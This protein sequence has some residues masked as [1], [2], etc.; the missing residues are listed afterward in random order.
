MVQT[1]SSLRGYEPI[2]IVGIGC[3]FPGGIVSPATFWDFLLRGQDGT[4]EVPETRW[5]LDRHYDPARGKPG[6]IY[7]KRGGFLENVEGF[8]SQFFGISPREAAY[9]DPQQRLLLEVTWEA[10]EDACIPIT[11]LAR[12]KVGVY[13]GLFTHDYENIH[14]RTTER[15][16][17]SVHSATGMSTTIAANRLSYVFDF[18]GPSMVIDTACSSSLVATHLACRALQAGEADLAVAGGVNLQ[19]A[20]DMAMAL[21][22]ASMLA[23]DGHS[24]SFDARANG[25]ARAEGAGVVVLKPLRKAQEDGDAVYAVIA[26]SAVNQ[27]GHSPGITVPH[28]L[29]QEIVMKEALA[30]AALSGA[31]LTYVEAHGTG[32]PVGD[33]IEAGALGAVLT[34]DQPGRLPCVVGSVKSNFGHAES[35]AGVAGLIKVALM[36]HNGRIPANLHFET[37]NPAIAFQ[38]LRLRVP[39]APEP[40]PAGE[41]GRRFA[42][43]N[44][45]GFGGTNAHV[46]VGRAPDVAGPA[47]TAP[48]HGPRLVCL[49]ARS[50]EALVESAANLAR[51]LQAPASESFD[52]LCG[53]LALGRAHLAERLLVVAQDRDEAGTLLEAFAEGVQGPGVMVGTA[54]AQGPLAF[55]CSGMG[56]Q[57]WGMGRDLMAR[58]PVFAAKIAEIDALFAALADDVSLA[59]LFSMDEQGSPINQTQMAQRAIFAVQIGLATLWEALGVRPDF[60]VGHSIGEVAASHIAGALSLPDA[61]TICFHRARLQSRLAGRGGMLAVGLSEEAVAAFLKEGGDAVAV[62]AINSP[63]SVTLSGPVEDLRRLHD[64]FEARQIFA[65]SLAVELPYHS[66]V[67]D[68]IGPEFRQQLQG[69]APRKT[70]I[71]LVSTVTGAVMDGAGLTPDYWVRNIREPVRFCKAMDTLIAC[72]CSLFVELGAHPVLGPSITE[73]VSAAGKTGSVIAS[74]RRHQEGGLAFWSA[75]GQLHCRGYDLPFERLARRPAQRVALPTYP[76]QR[77]PYWMES[78][79]SRRDRTGRATND[80]PL[81]HPLLGDRLTAPHPA[82]RGEIA[83]GRPAFLEDHRVQGS[84]VF[85][86]AGYLE[87]A[88]AAGWETRAGRLPVTL[89][90]VRIDAPLVLAETNACRIQVT[91]GEDGR[92]EIHSLTGKAEDAHWM[93]HASGI[94]QGEADRPPPER[95]EVDRLQSHLPIQEDAF[96]FYGRFDRTDLGYGPAFRNIKAVWVGT[97]TVLGRFG[98]RFSCED[99]RAAYLIHPAV[100]DSAFQL[101]AGL[102]DEGTFLPV[103]MERATVFKAGAPIAWACVTLTE[104]TSSRLK[105]NVIV[106]T[107]DG[108]VVATVEGLTCQRFD[109]VDR[110]GAADDPFLYRD[111]WVAIPLP[112]DDESGA[113]RAPLF[114]FDAVVDRVRARHG[115]RTR[116][117]AIDALT[118]RLDALAL[119]YVVEGLAALGWTWA[120]GQ[121]LSVDAMMEPLGITTRHRRF[122]ARMLGALEH[123]GV[124][125]ADEG[126]WR[127]VALPANGSAQE[128]WQRL[129]R[130]FPSCHAELVLVQR[131]GAGLSRFLI[132]E[133]EPLFALFPKDCPIAEQL[134]S[135]GPTIRPYNRVVADLVRE[136]VS[137]LPEGEVVRV[138]ELGAG[139]GGLTAHLLP[140]LP[141]ERTRYTFTDVSERF[142]SQARHRFRAYPFLRFEKLD[143]D[144]NPAEQGFAPGRF[145]L[146]LASNVLHA[147]A[148]LRATLTHVRHLL[149]PGGV[150]AAVELTTPPVWFDLVF[151]LLPGW[152]AFSDTTLRP[153]HATLPVAGWLD[154]LARSGFETPRAIV[155]DAE[156]GAGSHGVIL[157]RAPV[158]PGRLDG[159]TGALTPARD[160]AAFSSRPVLLVGEDGVL[161]DRVAL[162]VRAAGGRVLAL[163]PHC[164][165]HALERLGEAGDLAAPPIVVLLPPRDPSSGA[166]PEQVPSQEAAHRCADLQANVLA[167]AEVGRHVRLTLWIVTTG[168][169]PM[170]PAASACNLIGA[171]LKGF[172]RSVINECEEMDT[173]LI[174]LGPSPEADEVAALAR[175]VLSGSPEAE[176]VL[177]QDRRYVSRVHA[178]QP[179]RSTEALE[180]RYE[181]RKSSRPAPEDLVFH[182]GILADPGPGEVQLRIHASG[183][184]F[185]D[186][187]LLSGFI[188]GKEDDLGLEASGIIVSVGP[189]VVDFSPGDAVFGF[190]RHGMNAVVNVPVDVV[191]R[192]P[193]TVSLE[194]AAGI[195]VV[196]LS[197]Y[198]AL[199]RLAAVRRGQTVLVHTG[200]SGFGLAAIEVARALGAR[201][202]A[203]AG[204]PEKRAYLTARGVEFVGDS[205]SPAFAEA[206]MDHTGGVGVDVVLNTLPAA[207]IE[208]NLQVLRP[209]TGRLVDV[210]N[211][212]YDATLSFRAFARG[213]TVASFDLKTIALGHQGYVRDLLRELT[214]MFASGLLRP[215][216]HRLISIERLSESLHSLR[217]GAHIGKLI[218]THRDAWLPVVPTNR[219]FDVAPDASYLVTGGL[220]GFGLATAR[221]LAECG[222]RHLVLISRRGEATP[223]AVPGLAALKAM[224][225]AV[226]A[227]ACDVTDRK[228]LADLFDRFGRD[229][230]VLRGV[231]HGALVLRDRPLRA[232]SLDDIRAVL[233]PKIDGAWNLHHLCANQPLDFFLCYSSISALVGNR[234]QA[235]YAGANA[236]LEALMAMRRA[237]G[238]PGLA[239]GWGMIAQIGTVARD[240]EIME[241]L[242]RQ[243]VY[244][245]SPD[246]AWASVGVGLRDDLGY[247]GSMVADWKKLSRF[248]RVIAATPRFHLLISRLEAKASAGAEEGSFAASRPGAESPASGEDALERAVIRDI[249]SVLGMKPEAVD[250]KKPLPELGFDSLMSVELSL[251]LE[252]STGHRFNRMALLRPDV[253]AAL[254]ISTLRQEGATGH[255]NEQERTPLPPVDPQAVVPQAGTVNVAELSDDEVDALLQQLS[256][257]E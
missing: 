74:Q 189:G 69:I 29:A 64:L 151:G 2:A 92:F 191:A 114:P 214:G 229:L 108:D 86:A 43:V 149:R 236:Y 169:V 152:W 67:M 87:V 238:K 126:G 203:T 27:D 134:Y 16:L 68:E 58:E 185:K 105:A 81:A 30:A 192:K 93:R 248:A 12:H 159:G 103:G 144:V 78:A 184:N 179:L 38:A 5:N 138:L 156:E 127:V 63:G 76:W 19:L 121:S 106:A 24:K 206:V 84:V 130:A 70:Q 21:S 41:G 119:D 155:D 110:T 198:H 39:T 59:D 249:A 252:N 172:A 75:V 7:T 219:P 120:V 14:M 186:F 167:L 50:R 91:L 210:A 216:P 6:K 230:P 140:L 52:A 115:A 244:P 66:P 253:S 123:S 158:D 131:C 88:F 164:R 257:G 211:V 170:G 197:A 212:H 243:G 97:D 174:D 255:A 118:P 124:L 129:A 227:L 166:G 49:S 224:G 104:R 171:V 62:A 8:D 128:Q 222:A 82:W 26:G 187:A 178:W 232:L 83:P 148:D 47:P 31:D 10:F 113:T 246:K 3:R 125:R 101:L 181:L 154:V 90:G 33:P 22:N 157:A 15:D 221:W 98:S 207:F 160:G 215:V 117:R 199:K 196:F 175:E 36:Q 200:A 61:V 34:A 254:L 242:L 205:R 190:V 18:M 147:T 256:V 32:T 60:V 241:I 251:A 45:F 150:V 89:E 217:K 194:E 165:E 218:I 11:H 99:E 107:Q 180:A 9:M 139:T 71:P 122:V 4:R 247:L 208:H 1:K 137:H 141:P 48:D 188:E 145:D 42:G 245:L 112:G 136:I 100:L 25:Y 135:D 44:S 182:E 177:R 202:L 65:R 116:D 143:I 220:T 40:W 46:I 176:V 250:V 213:L 111:T 240:R 55:V 72:G 54:S 28:G 23:P 85:P 204:T 57:W 195:P 201:V 96:A 168:A 35:A 13:I 223:E 79:A 146:I 239:I 102:P 73:C 109:S 233:A 226:Q 77:A 237:A 56:Q 225:V 142:L 231:V 20:P 133:D 228:A 37:P 162:A 163:L 94:V 51:Y 173:H 95:M 161:R 193:D 132:G 153:A 234:D 53:A 80:G 209:V 183:I 235:N 17:H